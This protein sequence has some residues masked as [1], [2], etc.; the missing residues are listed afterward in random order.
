MLD[1]GLGLDGFNEEWVGLLAARGFGALGDFAVDDHEADLLLGAVS[2]TTRS[3]V[4][5]R[6]AGRWPRGGVRHRSGPAAGINPYDENS[7]R[8]ANHYA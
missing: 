4:L 5:T 2:V 6:A 8:V 1:T 7:L 3:A